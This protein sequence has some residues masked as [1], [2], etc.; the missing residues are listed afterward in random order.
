MYQRTFSLAPERSGVVTGAYCY[1]AACAAALAGYE[2]GG[3]EPEF[4]EL[5][6]SRWR[7]QARSWL[8][9]DLKYW[10]ERS[11][12]SRLEDLR[13]AAATLEYWQTDPDLAG[14]R[15]AARIAQLPEQER[16]SCEQLCAEV[17]SLLAL[18]R[19]AVSGHSSGTSADP[20]QDGH[21][22]LLDLVN[23]SKPEA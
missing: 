11:R 4:D 10:T 23:P 17:N 21:V 13:E 20:I 8:S 12:S 5:A 16:A 14:L 1:N 19:E 7:T 6:R 9:E 22:R 15:D 2:S 18:V 3:V